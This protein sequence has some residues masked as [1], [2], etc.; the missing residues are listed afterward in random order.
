MLTGKQ[1]S[2]LRS[3][4]NTMDPIIQIGKGGISPTVLNQ[5][6]ETLE[7]RE[8]IKVRVLQNSSEDPE[9]AAEQIAQELGAEVV[10]VLGRNMIFYRSS[11]KKPV[12]E[13]P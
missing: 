13:L 8:L 11:Q 10:H 3:L 5:I 1:K 9:E 7:A 6:N 12:I 4:A 2:Y